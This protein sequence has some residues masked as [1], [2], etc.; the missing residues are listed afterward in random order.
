MAKET[1]YKWQN[2]KKVTLTSSEVK[3]YIMRT[4][5]WTAEQYRKQYDIFK[6]KLRAYE[7][8][9][10]AQGVKVEQQ[11]VVNVLFK[12]AKAKRN[13]GSSYTPSR[14]MQQIRN[15]KAYSITKGRY[16]ATQ[17]KYI[18][19]EAVK[20]GEYITTRFGKYDPTNEDNNSGFIGNNKGAQEIVE[21]FRRQAE[22]TGK[23]INYVKMEQAL[24]DYADKVHARVDEED[25]VQEDEA[26][27]SG[28]TYGSDVEPTDFD[29]SD[30]L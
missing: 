14:K 2:G 3:Q 10:K 7:S 15:F 28:E 12:E 6:N 4:N 30:Y 11:S 25:R 1:F 13:Y 16:M 22:E 23:P 5:N 29:V 21:A 18:E 19:R 27:F 20:Y 24:S 26:I 17:E 9:Q 8:Y